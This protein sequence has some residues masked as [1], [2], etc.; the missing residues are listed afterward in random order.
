MVDPNEGLTMVD[1]YEAFRLIGPERLSLSGPN[2][3]SSTM[4]G[5]N[6]SLITIDPNGK[7]IR[8]NKG[9]TRSRERPTERGSMIHPDEGLP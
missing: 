2:V 6:A 9:L 1:P 8:P 4:T 5:P 3:E 7:L